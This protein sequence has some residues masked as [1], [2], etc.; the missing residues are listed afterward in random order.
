MDEPML[1]VWMQ[2]PRAAGRAYAERP[3][4]WVAEPAWPSPRIGTRA[5]ARRAAALGAPAGAT[6]R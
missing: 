5:A 4:R 3:G 6:P 1:R 2:E